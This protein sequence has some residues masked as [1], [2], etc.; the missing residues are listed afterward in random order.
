MSITNSVVFK[1]RLKILGLVRSI[2]LWERSTDSQ[3]FIPQKGLMTILD[4]NLTQCDW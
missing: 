4:P 3:S 2:E 1:I